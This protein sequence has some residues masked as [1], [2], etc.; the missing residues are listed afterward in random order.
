MG[1]GKVAWPSLGG[2]AGSGGCAK[3]A[4][5]AWLAIARHL[6]LCTSQ[7]SNAATAS[8]LRTVPGLLLGRGASVFH[9]T[10]RLLAARIVGYPYLRAHQG[11]QRKK[12][13]SLGLRSGSGIG[14][15]MAL[16]RMLPSLRAISNEI[17][18][19]SASRSSLPAASVVEMPHV[20]HVTTRGLQH[21]G[22]GTAWLSGSRSYGV[23][24]DSSY[25]LVST[26]AAQRSSFSLFHCM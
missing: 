7:Q 21:A 22:S 5:S 26:H 19:A 11:S 24:R 20:L 10:G 15:S 17:M 16:R 12:S 8:C 25:Y 3:C 14:I 9:G 4:A 2:G 13:A 6:Q 18:V 23:G 1:L